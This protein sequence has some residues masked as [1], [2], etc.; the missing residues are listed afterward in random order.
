M[1][2][3]AYRNSVDERTLMNAIIEAAEYH[4]WKWFHDQD[5]RKNNEGYPDLHLAKQGNLFFFETKTAT[6]RI[7][8]AQLEWL[9]ELRDGRVLSARIIRP[10]DLDEVLELIREAS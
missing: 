5:S 9:E 8:P 3:T 1:T 2:I 7:R 6:G 10:A 4:G